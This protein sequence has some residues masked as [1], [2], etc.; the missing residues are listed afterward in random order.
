MSGDGRDGN[1]SMATTLNKFGF[2]L[3]NSSWFFLVD[4]VARGIAMA[5]IPLYTT[6]MSPA[7]Y[8]IVAICLTLSQVVGSFNGLG[9]FNFADRLLYRF[10]GRP[11]QLSVLLGSIYAFAFSF[12]V[13]TSATLTFF[14]GLIHK[15]FFADSKLPSGAIIFIPIWLTFF[16]TVSEALCGY[17]M[18]NQL[19]RQHFA[20]NVTKNLSLHILKIIALVLLRLGVL[21]FLMAELVTEGLIAISS[22][23]VL[24]RMVKPR[25]VIRRRKIIRTGL[26]YG[27]PYIPNNL[28]GSLI[29]YFDR[30]LLLRLSGMW[31]VGLYSFAL[32]FTTSLF[33][34]A[35]NPIRSGIAPELPR[36]LDSP[37]RHPDAHRNM[38]EFL[39]AS[40][41]FF[42]VI[43]TS[44]SLF[45][46]EVLQTLANRRFHPAYTL[47][48]LFC[49]CLL[50]QN[51]REIVQ[52][53]IMIRN[54]TAFFPVNTF[55]AVA[56]NIV[57]N[58]I[59]IP[60]WGTA[61]AA[62]AAVLANF[63]LFLAALLY[64]QRLVRIDYSY[65]V[66]SLPI[67]ISSGVVVSTMCIS[68]VL[69][70]SLVWKAGLMV[71]YMVFCLSYVSR[72]CPK[73]AANI[74]A[75]SALLR[76]WS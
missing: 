9:L 36:Q 32:T 26:R 58:L 48:P 38:T 28:G 59:L 2:L 53:P 37:S 51:A 19:G 14:P 24:L 73:I 11:Q 23:V 21:G 56:V 70:A 4:V 44:I 35:W 43:M 72:N 18:I 71:L 57:A 8:G 54:K 27:L 63:G 34:L 39:Y 41:L 45:G 55:S 52:F 46:K 49:V 22:A 42:S 40:T 3:K 20:F 60:I 75:F 69:A 12:A 15:T 62:L 16:R 67:L 25:I 30:I 29:S 13:L 50:L 76:V 66:A 31:D 6:Y 64:A 17:Q 10:H 74:P 5:L 68:T 7:D 1:D 61:G 47:F 65:I 33:N